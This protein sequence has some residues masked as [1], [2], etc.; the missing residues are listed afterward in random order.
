MTAGWGHSSAEEGAGPGAA[1]CTEHRVCPV[2]GAGGEGQECTPSSLCSPPPPAPPSWHSRASGKEGP[3][4]NVT[5]AL[6]QAYW[7]PRR[8]RR[9]WRHHGE[10][11]S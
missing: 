1:I 11:S 2:V 3:Q 9:Q 10:P 6:S 5:A 8:A 4:A 7:Q